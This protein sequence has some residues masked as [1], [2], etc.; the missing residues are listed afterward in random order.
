MVYYEPREVKSPMHT[1]GRSELWR[2]DAAELVEGYSRGLFTP[3]DALDACLERMAKCQPALNAMVLVDRQGAR[4]AAEASWHRW[5]AGNPLGPLDGV[6]VSVK[7]NMHVAGWRTSWGSRLLGEFTAS[8]D[9]LPVKRLRAAGAVL[10]GKTNLPEFAMQGYTSNPLW[11]TTRNPWDLKLTPGGSS[12]GA[13]AAV[14]A[15]CGPLALATDGGGSIRRPASHCGLVGFKPS[16]G[17][18]PRARGLP[19]I[20]LEYEVAG[21]IGRSL[22]DVV[23][24]AS[25]LAGTDLTA[26]RPRWAKVLFVP[27][28]GDHPVDGRIAALV[29]DTAVCL[30][31]LGHAVDEAP[32]FDVAEEINDRWPLLSAAGLAWMFDNPSARAELGLPADRMPDVAL[33]GLAPQASLRQGQAAGATALFDILI[34]IQTL[35]RR[36]DEI[37]ARYDFILTPATAALPWPAEETHPPEIAGHAVGPRGHA[38]FTAVANAA[39]LPAIALPCGWVGGLPT[40]FQLIARPGGDASL[41]ALAQQYQQA[42]PWQT[43]WPSTLNLV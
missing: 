2:L 38:V 27:R 13:V 5:Q 20:F 34:A 8:R 21:P 24:L 3:V 22:R 29:K 10:F 28:F 31:Q 6:A 35:K 16:I 32:S 41:L 1:E 14:A 43:V 11:G 33:C 36:L 23:T 40:G 15:G 12:G 18:V 30:E 17:L 26:P 39:G 25:V 9:E 37:F 19:G 4:A 7:D 42:Q